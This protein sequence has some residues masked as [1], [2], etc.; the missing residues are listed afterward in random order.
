MEDRLRGLPTANLG[1]LM[2]RASAD[3]TGTRCRGKLTSRL[4]REF[5]DA[6]LLSSADIG[7]TRSGLRGV[8]RAA[9]AART[10]VRSGRCAVGPRVTRCASGVKWSRV[11]TVA[12]GEALLVPA[13]NSLSSGRV[14]R[15]PGSCKIEILL[16]AQWMVRDVVPPTGAAVSR[17]STSAG[18]PPFF[19]GF[20]DFRGL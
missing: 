8:S 9:S 12:C 6:I 13:R 4:L 15:L 5:R 7:D 10:S 17:C 2:D 11:F 1:V 3:S 20:T 14:H 19:D 16:R 18:S